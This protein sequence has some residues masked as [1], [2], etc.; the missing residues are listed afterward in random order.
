MKQE[1]LLVFANILA[2]A[3]AFWLWMDFDASRRSLVQT[4]TALQRSIAF[5]EEIDSLRSELNSRLVIEDAG[6]DPSRDIS[7]AVK[8]ANLYR[9]K[10]F[11]LREL[12]SRNIE[13]TKVDRCTVLLPK[14]QLSLRKIVNLVVCLADADPNFQV[15]N[16]VLNRPEKVT[17]TTTN[18]STEVWDVDFKEIVYLRSSQR[19]D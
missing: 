7:M 13:S 15:A 14:Y 9:K 2:V 5:A 3:T 18:P 16:M 6:F 10:E 11:S 17:D 4:D 12:S 1:K 19:D 8:R